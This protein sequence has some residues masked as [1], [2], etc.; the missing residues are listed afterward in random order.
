M[1]GPGVVV[2]QLSGSSDLSGQ[3]GF[4]SHTPL[5]QM[6]VPSLQVNVSQVVGGRVVGAGVVVLRTHW[7]QH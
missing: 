2:K 7:P 6:T 4:L 1:V 5:L 3:S